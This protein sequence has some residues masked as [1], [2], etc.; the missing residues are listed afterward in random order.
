VCVF[1]YDGL[2]MLRL[3]QAEFLLVI[4]LR[5]EFEVVIVPS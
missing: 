2:N 4:A 3:I 1:V 5:T